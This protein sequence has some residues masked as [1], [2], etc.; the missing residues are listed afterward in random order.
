M[1]F[2][3]LDG[4]GFLAD[5]LSADFSFKSSTNSDNERKYSKKS[6]YITELWSGSF[7]VMASILCFVVFNDSLPQENYVQT[8]L[9]CILIGFAVSFIIFFVLYHL[10]LYYFKSLSKLL[11][12]SFSFVC[13][14]IALVLVAYF[15]LILII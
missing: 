3:F 15:K 11:L 10:E 7:L 9:V 1:P 6:K 14:M 5:L 12:F 13:L 2:D 8:L 4:L